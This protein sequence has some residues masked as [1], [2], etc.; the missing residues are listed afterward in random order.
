ML[1]DGHHE[2]AAYT[3][4]GVAARVLLLCRTEDT[5]GPPDAPGRPFLAL[6]RAASKP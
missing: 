4:L 2:T 3:E 5:W 1:L 6:A